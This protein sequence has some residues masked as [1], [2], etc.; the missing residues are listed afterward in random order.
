M[1]LNC[2][3]CGKKLTGRWKNY[4]SRRCGCLYYIKNNHKETDL[5][6]K[7][8]LWLE[9]QGIKFEEQKTIGNITV[10][11]FVIG[12]VILF[13]DGEFWHDRPRRV[14]T[15]ARINKRLEKLGYKV[16]RYKGNDI[17]H[18][19]DKVAQDILSNL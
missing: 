8:R 5:E 10:P 13:V 6:K 9:S 12:N 17:L 11:D 14:F 16:L 2:K 1:E 7:M 15:D 3:N 19:F 4:C 18:N